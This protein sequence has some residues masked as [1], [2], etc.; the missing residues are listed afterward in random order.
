MLD[1]QGSYA[2]INN[3]IWLFWTND[4]NITILHDTP[5]H[6]T[7]HASHAN[8]GTNFHLSLVYAKCRTILRR[9]LW[10]DLISFSTNLQ[11][12]WSVIGDFNVIAKVVEKLGGTPYR[13]EKSFDLLNFMEDAGIQDAGYVGNIH[14]WSNNKGA[15]NT[16]WKRLDRMLYN[17]EWFDLF[18]KT[19]FTHLARTG[20]DHAPL[21]I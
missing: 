20:S 21:L 15:P 14:T 13:L 18:N 1:M 19:T 6:V 8:S 16:I 5:Q 10:D 12:P 3:K 7:C 2:T 4:F 11:G 9:S 17:A